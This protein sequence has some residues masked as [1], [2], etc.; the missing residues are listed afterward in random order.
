M[1]ANMNDVWRSIDCFQDDMP[2]MILQLEH[3]RKGMVNGHTTEQQVE[4]YHRGCLA[5]MI[6]LNLMFNRTLLVASSPALTNLHILLRG[7]TCVVIKLY[8]PFSTSCGIT[9]CAEWD[10]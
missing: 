9:R 2:S 4:E 6:L 7:R 1:S 10:L 8:I 5:L 3:K